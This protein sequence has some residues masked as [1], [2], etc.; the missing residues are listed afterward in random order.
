MP[1]I[2]ETPGCG[3]IQRLYIS[4]D[5]KFESVLWNSKC[6]FLAELWVVVCIAGT[7]GSRVGSMWGHKPCLDLE[8]LWYVSPS[9]TLLSLIKFSIKGCFSTSNLQ[10]S[11]FFLTFFKYQPVFLPHLLSV[12]LEFYKM[13]SFFSLLRFIQK[14][15]RKR[16]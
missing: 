2:F 5:F 3:P 9:T 7:D 11:F 15:V 16:L 8:H 4:T 13:L 1:T 6:K 14:A 10:C 12:F